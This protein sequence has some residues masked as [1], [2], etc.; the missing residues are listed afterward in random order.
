M[1]RD[2]HNIV[3]LFLAVLL[4]VLLGTSMILGFDFSSRKPP[5]M[6]LVIKGTLVADSTIV[7]PP[8]KE[9]PAP[10]EP[11]VDTAA[12]EQARIAAEE[13]KRRQQD[14]ARKSGGQPILAKRSSLKIDLLDEWSRPK[15]WLVE[16]ALEL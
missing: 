13:E 3:P 7:L 16:D 9:Q 11:V 2:N 14:D 4:H 12:L 8:P 6:P 15:D 5:P 1:V 10:P